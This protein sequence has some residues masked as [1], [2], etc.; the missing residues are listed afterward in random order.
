MATDFIQLAQSAPNGVN[1]YYYNS[2]TGQVGNSN[3][4][5]YEN[6]TNGNYANYGIAAAQAGSSGVWSVTRPS[7]VVEP[8]T[9]AVR[10]SASPSTLATD[11]VVAVSPNSDSLNSNVVSINNVSASGVTTIDPVIG[12]S[13]SPIQDTAS[14]ALG[15]DLLY[16][17]QHAVAA[18]GSTTFP[19]A[20][21]ASTTNITAAVVTSVT[22]NVGGIAGTTN[23]FDD[24]QTALNSTHGAGSWTTATGFALASSW[25]SALATGLGTTNSLA[26]G[27]N[28]FAAIYTASASANTNASAANTAIGLIAAGTTVVRAND[29]QGNNLALASVLAAKI[30]HNLEFVTD[31]STGG[32]LVKASATATIGVTGTAQGGTTNSITIASGDTAATN[33][34]EGQI[35]LIIGGTGIGQVALIKSNDGTSKVVV[36]QT[37]YPGQTWLITPDNTSVY[38][39][40]GFLPTITNEITVNQVDVNVTQ[41]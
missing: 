1:F 11:T 22:G 18:T 37:V 24:L 32:Y 41:S 35:I 31:P 34:Y 9:I 12:L 10:L 21:L 5:A 4:S 15:V 25:T 38:Q 3:T 2:S 23:T 30:A 19:T 29:Y 17:N 14:G 39:L 27:A 8:V 26:A 16:I 36:I 33:V 28:G 6:W 20:T 40:P 13:Q 7:W